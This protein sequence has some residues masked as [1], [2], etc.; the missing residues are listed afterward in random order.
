MTD[1]SFELWQDDIMVASV[2]SSNL[3]M[4]RQEIMHYAMMYAQ[5]GPCEIRGKS[6]GLLRPISPPHDGKATP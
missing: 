3:K 6:A 5:D 1:Y 4:A 2:D